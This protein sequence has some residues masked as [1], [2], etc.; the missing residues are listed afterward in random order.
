M[1]D[2]FP[3]G[4]IGEEICLRILVEL[5]LMDPVGWVRGHKG[6]MRLNA[7]HCISVCA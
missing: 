4:W 3:Y 7:I 5:Q 6:K 2:I 1:S